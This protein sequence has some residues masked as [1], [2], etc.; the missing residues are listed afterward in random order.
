[1]RDSSE[2][3]SSATC[4]STDTNLN[5]VSTTSCK[6]SPV[7]VHSELSSISSF[8]PSISNVDGDKC[9]QPNS[10]VEKPLGKNT[11]VSGFSNNFS[12]VFPDLLVNSEITPTQKSW[13]PDSAQRIGG[14]DF[15]TNEANSAHFSQNIHDSLPNENLSLGS[16]SATESPISDLT[17]PFSIDVA[18]PRPLPLENCDSSS[19]SSPC[20]STFGVKCPSESLVKF[21]PTQDEAVC[22]L[23]TL[24][25]FFSRSSNSNLIN[26]NEYSVVISL[27]QKIGSQ[28]LLYYSKSDSYT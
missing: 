19:F 24:L 22:A 23:E 2:I 10:W 15:P 9:E 26:E 18:V 5:S 4:S 7:G 17:P 11:S 14:G 16:L 1:M 3:I 6:L 13:K 27:R 20:T 21:P 12:V 8:S 25:D 28:D